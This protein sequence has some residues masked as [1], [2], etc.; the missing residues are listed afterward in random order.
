MKRKNRDQQV[1][2]LHLH[3]SSLIPSLVSGFEKPFAERCH[4]LQLRGQWRPLTAFPD[5]SPGCSNL[6]ARFV[7]RR[8]A[9]R[10]RHRMRVH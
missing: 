8:D 4:R 2:L 9:W 6:P 5:P 7:H 3:P 1:L 10:A